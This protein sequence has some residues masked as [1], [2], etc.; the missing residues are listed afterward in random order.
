[1]RWLGSITNLM[2]MNLSKLGDSEGQGRLA[3]CSPWGSKQSDMTYRL[4]SNK[5]L[6]S[7]HH[8]HDSS[9]SSNVLALM[10]QQ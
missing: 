10:L 9:R 6:C 5:R 7:S 3:C 1:M 4:N 2:D 8:F